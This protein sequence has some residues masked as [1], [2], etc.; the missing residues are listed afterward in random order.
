MRIAEGPL[1]EVAGSMHSKYHG[2]LHIWTNQS[3][4]GVTRAEKLPTIDRPAF[5][6]WRAEYWKTRVR[7]L[8]G[9]QG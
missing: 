7:E 3:K 8:V 4:G 5:D 2:V 1:A 6:K 9:E